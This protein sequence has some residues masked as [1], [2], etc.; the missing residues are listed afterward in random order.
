MKRHIIFGFVVVAIIFL[1]GSSW[2][3]IPQWF[4]D[5]ALEAGTFGD[6]FGAVNALFSGL[7]FAGLKGILSPYFIYIKRDLSYF[8]TIPFACLI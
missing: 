3:F 4:D 8:K 2:Y 6:M 1:W 7:A 5:K